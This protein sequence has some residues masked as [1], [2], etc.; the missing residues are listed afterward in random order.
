ML[1]RLLSSAPALTMSAQSAGEEEKGGKL[2]L[3]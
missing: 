1:F 3:G 2:F